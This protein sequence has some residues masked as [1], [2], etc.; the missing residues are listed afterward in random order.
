[1]RHCVICNELFGTEDPKKL[2]CTSD[3]Q[4]KYRKMVEQEE[5]Q[6][7]KDYDAGKIKAKRLMD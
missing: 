7:N 5:K 2:G 6:W 1:M 3:C 4:K